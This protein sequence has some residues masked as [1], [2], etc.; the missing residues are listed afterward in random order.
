MVRKLGL[1]CLLVSVNL[2]QAMNVKNIVHLDKSTRAM[3]LVVRMN[4]QEPVLGEQIIDDAI[5]NIAIRETPGQCH[6]GNKD[7]C[8]EKFLIC[9]PA[10]IE[11]LRKVEVEKTTA[12]FGNG[13]K[14]GFFDKKS[15]K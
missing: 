7:V 10:V 15:K 1:M 5:I 13:F 11:A 3:H 9:S 2:V 8:M 6:C 4:G 14:K 12:T